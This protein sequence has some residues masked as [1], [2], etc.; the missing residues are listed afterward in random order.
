MQQTFL[1]LPPERQEEI[2]QVAY[3]EFALKGYQS[4][5]LSEII[6]KIGVAKGSFY[7]YFLSKK[8]L[9]VYLLKTATER[10]YSNLDK[11]LVNPEI[12][13]FELIKLNFKAIIASD[14]EDPLVSG[15]IYQ[16]VHERDTNEVSDI[17]ESIYIQVIEKIKLIIGDKKYKREL[18]GIDP[19]F[20]AFHV[21][22][23]QL[24]FYDYISFKYKINYEENIRNHLPIMNLPDE[25]LDRIS[26][27]S[28]ELLKYGLKKDA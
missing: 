13:F 12:G 3:E 22:Y 7:R 20:I 25:E 9:F 15:F 21:F 6:R 5:S 2:L 19:D 1:N 10:R 14:K 27:M 28:V 23:S 11:L 4:A 18:K 16:V 26:D 17:I 24:W 8:E